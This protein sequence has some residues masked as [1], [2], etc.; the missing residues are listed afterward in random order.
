MTHHVESTTYCGEV[1]DRAINEV[2]YERKPL[3]DNFLYE[4]SALMLYAD[5]GSG[6]S[7][8][9]LQTCLQATVGGSKLFSNCLSNFFVTLTVSVTNSCVIVKILSNTLIYVNLKDLC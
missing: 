8:L 5:D 4:K 1:L 6:K 7:A 3:I 9:C 2:Q